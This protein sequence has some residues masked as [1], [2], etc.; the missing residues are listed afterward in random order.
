MKLNLTW[1]TLL[2]IVWFIHYFDQL[3]NWVCIHLY[4]VI[5]N[6]TLTNLLKAMLS[7]NHFFLLSLTLHMSLQRKWAHVHYSSHLLSDE[8]MWAHPCYNHTRSRI[9]TT[10]ETW[11]MMWW[12]WRGLG[13]RLPASYGCRGSLSS[14]DVIYLV[15]LYRSPII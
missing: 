10:R 4:L 14:Y 5:V 11:R 13:R 2:C 7:L 6:K 8:H 3:F 15:I 1:H 12:V 9:G